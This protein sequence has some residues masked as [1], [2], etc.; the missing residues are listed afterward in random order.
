MYR[1]TWL[2]ATGRLLLIAGTSMLLSPVAAD[3]SFEGDIPST[4]EMGSSYTIEWSTDADNVKIT[5]VSGSESS[6][7][8]FHL[9][10]VVCGVWIVNDMSKA[11][12]T[13]KDSLEWTPPD[14][15]PI[16]HY[17]LMA[18]AADDTE[19]FSSQFNL[20][21]AGDGVSLTWHKSFVHKNENKQINKQ[22]KHDREIADA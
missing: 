6:N 15:L 17:M 9:Y 4:L 22:T 5:M 20:V 21:E 1:A 8:I 11:C 7:N 2:N 12:T 10:D 14:D 18:N 19:A 13:T 3:V 16:G